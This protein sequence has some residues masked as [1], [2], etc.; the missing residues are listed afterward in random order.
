MK[1]V[2]ENGRFGRLKSPFQLFGRKLRN[3]VGLAAGFDKDGEAIENLG[4]SGFGMVRLV[5]RRMTLF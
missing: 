1:G 3:P 5:N 2:W 4:K